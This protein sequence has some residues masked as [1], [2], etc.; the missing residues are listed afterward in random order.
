M[1]SE[2]L[3]IFVR[4]SLLYTVCLVAVF[5][6]LQQVFVAVSVIHNYVSFYVASALHINEFGLALCGLTY[7]T[8][9]QNKCSLV[10]KCS[11]WWC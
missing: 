11:A 1:Y 2:L 6:N 7:A 9:W 10:I 3:S 8:G 4:Q 5:L